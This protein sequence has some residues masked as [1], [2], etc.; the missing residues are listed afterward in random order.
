LDAVLFVNI[1]FANITG[2]PTT[3]T[4]RAVRS[5]YVLSMPRALVALEKL[6]DD[7]GFF[8]GRFSNWR[9]NSDF[10]LFSGPFSLL[11]LYRIYSIAKLAHYHFP[12]S[13]QKIASLMPN[14]GCVLSVNPKMRPSD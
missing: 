2:G 13:G 3:Q 6:M 4:I 7:R 10:M 11:L 12:L 1:P 5:P 9:P 14:L 8:L